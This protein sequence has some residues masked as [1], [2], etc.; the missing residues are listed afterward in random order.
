MNDIK[1]N[2]LYLTSHGFL[3]DSVESLD[4]YVTQ[5]STSRRD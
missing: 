2:T 1:L 3:V 5:T 4:Q